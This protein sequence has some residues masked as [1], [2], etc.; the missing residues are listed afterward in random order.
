LTF[1]AWLAVGATLDFTITRMVTVLVIACPHALGLAIPL[2]VA[3]STT[4]GASNGLLVRDRRGLEEARNLNVVVF[5]KTGTLT[6]GEHRVVETV[7]ADSMKQDD[8]LRLAAA[9]ERDSEHPIAQALLKSAHERGLDVPHAEGFQ[10]IAGHGVEATVEGRQLKVGGP[11]LLQK[12]DAKP[13]EGLREAADRFGQAGQAA[14]YLVEAS[15]VLAAFAV[16][17]AIRPESHEAIQRLHDDGIEVAMLTGDSRAVADSVARELGIDIV[18]AEVLPRGQ[19]GQDQGAAIPGQARRHGGRRGQRRPGAADRRR[20][21]RHRGR[22]R[23]GG[24]SGRR[25]AGAQRSARRGTDR[26]PQPRQL[27]QDGAEPVVGGGLQRR[28]HSARRRRARLGRHPA[29]AGGGRHSH[30]GEHGDCGDQRAAAAA[31]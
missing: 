3:I 15:H 22:H 31:R 11:A 1:A 12:L 2:V 16:A 25:G 4:M 23:R 9:V 30:V 29:G 28:R 20:R 5:D 7:V 6:L 10:A 13:P 24:G 8:A 19:G 18:F 17:D 21:H 27:P 26:P 14:I